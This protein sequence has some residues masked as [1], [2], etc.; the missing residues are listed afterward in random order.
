[1]II[2]QIGQN[3]RKF[4]QMYQRTRK[5]MALHKALQPS[6]DIDSMCREKK[7]GEYSPALRS[8]LKRAKKDYL[9]QP[10]KVIAT[11]DQTENQQKRENKNVRKNNRMDISSDQL[12][13]F[14]TRKPRYGNERQTSREKLNLF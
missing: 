4:K 12:T 14:P 5:L 10:V 13:R 1:M 11:L 9:D 6:E 7:E 8:T 3:G 2:R